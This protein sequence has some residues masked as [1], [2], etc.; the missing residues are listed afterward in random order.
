M[1]I[2]PVKQ[3]KH[4]STL[5]EAPVPS[6]EP[7]L[8]GEQRVMAVQAAPQSA[9]PRALFQPSYLEKGRINSMQTSLQASKSLSSPASRYAKPVEL[10][11]RVRFDIDR[12]VFRGRG[13][14]FGTKF[15]P[16]SMSGVGALLFLTPAERR[17]LSQVEGRT[18][19][20]MP[21]RQTEFDPRNRPVARDSEPGVPMPTVAPPGAMPHSRSALATSVATSER[22]AS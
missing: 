11:K 13:F 6:N 22:I 8:V 5:R 2:D 16:D 10:S 17:Y 12:D 19:A 18:Y 21:L 14:D 3:M 15:L 1:R 9:A 7:R 20:N 4:R